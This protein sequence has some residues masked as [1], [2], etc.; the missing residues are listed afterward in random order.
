MYSV[1]KISPRKP[2]AALQCEFLN[3]VPFL[4]AGIDLDTN[5]W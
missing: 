4:Q 5:I 3:L 2:G 1:L